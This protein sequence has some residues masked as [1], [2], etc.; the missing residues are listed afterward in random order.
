MAKVSDYHIVIQIAAIPILI[1]IVAIQILI[2]IIIA[3]SMV[4]EESVGDKNL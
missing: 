1:V 4:L 2:V 3:V